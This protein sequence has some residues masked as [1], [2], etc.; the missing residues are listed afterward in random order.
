MSDAFGTLGIVGSFI[1]ATAAL[2]ARFWPRPADGSRWLPVYQLV[3][4][5]AQN[6]GHATNATDPKSNG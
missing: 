6:G 5:L 3:N 4:M 1:I 2:I